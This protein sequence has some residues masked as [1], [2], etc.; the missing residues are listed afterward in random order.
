MFD[1]DHFKRVNDTWG[2]AV[3]DQVLVQVA[4]IT[5]QLLRATDTAGRLGG[6]EF[7]ILLP[8]TTLAGARQL[9][10]RLRQT[11][12]DTPVEGP[13]DT[14]NITASLGI[15][16]FPAHDTDDLP[17]AMQRADQALYIA[18]S[19]GRNCVCEL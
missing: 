10:E 3:G 14:F 11:I 15:T 7:M 19:S 5:R 8:S 18:K 1:L 12:A 13:E 2:H 17:Q 16:L 4:G 9:A 6:E